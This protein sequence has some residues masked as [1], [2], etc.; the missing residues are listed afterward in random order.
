MQPSYFLG[1]T[2]PA[3]FYF[4]RDT[5]RHADPAH[6]DRP[7]AWVRSRV[8]GQIRPRTAHDDVVD[9]WPAFEIA[10]YVLE[11][12]LRLGIAGVEADWGFEHE[13]DE[14]GRAI[15]EIIAEAEALEEELEEEEHADDRRREE[16]GVEEEERC[17]DWRDTRVVPREDRIMTDSDDEY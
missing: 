14:V 5:S 1:E 17:D 3:P 11:E 6:R 8:T 12:R 4:R 13:N 7:H 9:G 10:H 2:V 16:E 15:R